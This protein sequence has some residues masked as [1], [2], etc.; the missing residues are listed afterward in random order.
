MTVHLFSY[1]I[2]LNVVLHDQTE[3]DDLKV[4]VGRGKKSCSY[5]DY[6]L[7][8]LFTTNA[9][10]I[11]ELVNIISMHVIDITVSHFNANGIRTKGQKSHF[12]CYHN[13]DIDLVHGNF[14]KSSM[15][16]SK[17]A[18]YNMVCQASNQS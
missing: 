10:R 1:T 4:M 14:L 6:L 11:P 18:K 3:V 12:L 9:G 16:G 15:S 7:S 17:I 13:I 8:L 2:I 5:F